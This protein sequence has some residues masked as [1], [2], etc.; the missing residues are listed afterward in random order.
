MPDDLIADS[1]RPA[2][3][4][5]GFN[6]THWSVVLAAGESDAARAHAALEQLCRTYWFPLYAYVRRRGSGPHEAQ[7]LTQE[8]F[9]RLLDKQS[10]RLADSRRG[11][12]R[13]FLLTSLKNFL[14]N[15]W[16]KGHAAK[17][18]NGQ[19][20]QP[21]EFDDAERRYLAE[22]ARDLAPDRLFE[23][24]WAV[25]V[26]ERAQARLR[27]EYVAANKVPLFESLKE[28]VWGE[29]TDAYGELA[30][31][32]NTTEGALRI[33]AHRMKERFRTLLREEVAHTAASAEEIDDELRHLVSLLRG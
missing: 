26:V 10:L 18:G 6:T 17:R 21:L 29:R 16:Q 5:Y 20:I 24:R 25:A 13:S 3:A 32:L 31:Q 15:E 30:A 1:D 12:F 7:D 23:K 4:D 33:A 9:L 11:K 8:F 14:I 19:P 27:G 2:R 22:P 28:Q